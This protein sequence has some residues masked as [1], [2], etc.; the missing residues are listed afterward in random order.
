MMV[1][2]SLRGVGSLSIAAVMALKCTNA[3]NFYYCRLVF[4]HKRQVLIAVLVATNS[5]RT[6]VLMATHTR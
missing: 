4:W 3:S 6:V 5:T 1:L 2:D